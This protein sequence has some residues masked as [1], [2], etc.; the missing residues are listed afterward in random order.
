MYRAKNLQEMQKHTLKHEPV[1]YTVSLL[2]FSKHG[3]DLLKHDHILHLFRGCLIACI[4]SDLSLHVQPGLHN[5]ICLIDSFVS[6][7]GDCVNF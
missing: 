5:A 3:N 6:T 7:L 2:Y 1:S 4:F